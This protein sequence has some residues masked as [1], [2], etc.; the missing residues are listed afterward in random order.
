L[1]EK[2]GKEQISRG[3]RNGDSGGRRLKS[4]FDSAGKSLD[5]HCAHS[6]LIPKIAIAEQVMLRSS[7]EPFF[8]CAIASS[9]S[10][11]QKM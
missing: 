3:G 1:R 10:I 2:C 9:F 11:Y 4:K 5:D 7:V 6:G 8:Q